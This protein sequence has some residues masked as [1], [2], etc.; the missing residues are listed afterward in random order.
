MKKLNYKKMV[1]DICKL[2]ETDFH[3]DMELRH[4]P[5][6]EPYTQEETRKMQDTIGK[7]Y[8]I[9]HCISCTACQ[10]KYLDDERE[11]G[12]TMAGGII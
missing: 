2:V 11:A 6:S 3:A 9:S 5:D 7:V 1:E 12:G 4:L 10:V 8:L